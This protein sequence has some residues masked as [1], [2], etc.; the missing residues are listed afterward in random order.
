MEFQQRGSPH[1]HI[2]V[3]V[4]NAPQFNVETGEAIAAYVEQFLKCYIDNPIVGCL[5]E[6]QIHK[7][8]STCRKRE[9]KLCRFGYP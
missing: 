1:I 9:D 7:H 2:L 3:W 4:E 5:I 6:L 8:S